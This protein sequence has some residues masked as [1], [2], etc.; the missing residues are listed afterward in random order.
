MVSYIETQFFFSNV[1]IE[2]WEIVSRR[3]PALT[4]VFP[5]RNAPYYLQVGH[6]FGVQ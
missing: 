1:M 3:N 4:Y 5:Y 6:L 2:R